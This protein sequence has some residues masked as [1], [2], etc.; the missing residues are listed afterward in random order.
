MGIRSRAVA[1]FI[2]DSLQASVRTD[3]DTLGLRIVGAWA[4][5]RKHLDIV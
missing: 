4:R 1:D 5:V 3:A 2:P